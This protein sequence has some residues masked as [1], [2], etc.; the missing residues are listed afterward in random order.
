MPLTR[1][2]ALLNIVVEEQ[3]T[4]YTHHEQ[5]YGAIIVHFLHDSWRHLRRKLPICATRMVIND[6]APDTRL[7]RPRPAGLMLITMDSPS[8]VLNVR[9][10]K[11][12]DFSHSTRSVFFFGISPTVFS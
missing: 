5:L 3:S 10:L 12:L 9:T 1:P 8:D 7:H 6:D 4:V 2:I 11:G